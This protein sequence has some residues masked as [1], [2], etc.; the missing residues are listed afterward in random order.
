MVGFFKSSLNTNSFRPYCSLKHLL[1][2]NLMIYSL[3]WDILKTLRLT[4][5]PDWFTVLVH[6]T[7]S[8]DCTS[9]K[10]FSKVYFGVQIYFLCIC[11]QN[12]SLLCRRQTAILSDLV[13]QE[14]WLVCTETGISSPALYLSCF[15]WI[16]LCY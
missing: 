11:L 15:S 13:N 2:R 5:A 6:L 7:G 3:G 12:V 16:F 14:A 4:A 9:V 1:S 8:L 10:W